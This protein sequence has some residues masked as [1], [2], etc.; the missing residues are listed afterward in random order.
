MNDYK[1]NAVFSKGFNSIL[2]FIISLF[3][4]FTATDSKGAAVSKEVLVILCSNVIFEYFFITVLQ[5]L[6]LREP[7]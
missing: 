6:I 4:S 1:A 2:C 5:P 7:Q 3:Y